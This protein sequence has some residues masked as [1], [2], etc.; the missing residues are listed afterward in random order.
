MHLDIYTYSLSLSDSLTLNQDSEVEFRPGILPH[1][2]VTYCDNCKSNVYHLWPGH[3]PPTTA[4]ATRGVEPQS[5]QA[6]VDFVTWRFGLPHSCFNCS[7]VVCFVPPPCAQPRVGVLALLLSDLPCLGSNRNE[8]DSRNADF[9]P[10][11]AGC[12]G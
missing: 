3:L 11:C 1:K 12:V 8:P 7:F 2:M 9:V 6:A 10:W 5:L 4:A